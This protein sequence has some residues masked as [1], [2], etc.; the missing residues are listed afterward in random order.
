MIRQESSFDGTCQV[1]HLF[2]NGSIPDLAKPTVVRS[3]SSSHL[4]D[5][6]YLP[7]VA[8]SPHVYLIW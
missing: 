4:I 5:Q 3:W 8:K 6:K 7:I 1:I 2:W